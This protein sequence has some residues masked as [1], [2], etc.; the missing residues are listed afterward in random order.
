MAISLERLQS[1]QR[2]WEI[3]NFGEQPRV[4]SYQSFLGVVEEV[5]EL[6]HAILKREQRIRYSEAEAIDKEKNA[7]GDIT[8]F[9]AAYCT[10]RGYDYGAIVEEVWDEV[11]RRNWKKENRDYKPEEQSDMDG[12]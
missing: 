1:E 7:V 8:V 6:A 12:R 11:R 10:R 5:G 9:L 2:V 4:M 3:E